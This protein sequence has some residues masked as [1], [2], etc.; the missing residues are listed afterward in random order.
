MNAFRAHY[1]GGLDMAEADILRRGMSGKTRSSKELEKVK[2]RFF[3]NCKARG[4]PDELTQ[5]V[6]RQIESF[7]G[8][9]FCKS[10]SASYA[11]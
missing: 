2:D 3:S 10:H 1:F 9:S 11:V 4:Y 8:F 7:A 6:F 5:E